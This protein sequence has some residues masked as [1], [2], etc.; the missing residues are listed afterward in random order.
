MEKQQAS[1]NP[2]GGGGLYLTPDGVP[3]PVHPDDICSSIWKVLFNVTLLTEKCLSEQFHNMSIAKK[4]SPRSF[5]KRTGRR[6][7]T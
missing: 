4:N 7:W 3:E 2:A 5:T 1:D 6:I